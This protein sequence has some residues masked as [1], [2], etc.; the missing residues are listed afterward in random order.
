MVHAAT[1][2]RE[3]VTIQLNVEVV[4]YFKAESARTGI[5]YQRIINFYPAD[6]ANKGMKLAFS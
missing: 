1:T 4:D 2:E 3:E 5:P 6:C